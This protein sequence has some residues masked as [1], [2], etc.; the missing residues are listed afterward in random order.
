[1]GEPCANLR[2]GRIGFLNVLPVYFPLESGAVRHPFTIISG[3]PSRLNELAAKGML[4]I[5]PVSSIEYARHAGLY[6][7]V[8]DLSISSFGEVKSVLLLSR[9]PSDR[10]SGAKV[11]VSSQSHTSVGLLKIL[12][13]LRFKVDPAFEAGSFADFSGAEPPEAFLAIGDEALRLSKSGL[14]PYVLDLGTTWYEWTGLPFVYALWVISKKTIE[15]RN[16]YAAAAVEALLAS[17][18]WGS[19]H[20]RTICREAAQV[21]LLGIDE[22][23][24]YYQCLRYDLNEREKRGLELFFSYLL[25]IGELEQIPR[26]DVFTPLASVA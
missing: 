12:C 22:L 24:E 14:Y 11:L 17:K 4:D 3:V 9:L 23:E 7:I 19:M 26:L 13:R 21:G 16:G 10:L 25:E 5:S 1:M 6:N 15:E 8:P 20:M 18:Q 2:L